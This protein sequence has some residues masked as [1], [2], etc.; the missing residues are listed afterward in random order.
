MYYHHIPLLE[1]S[2][3]RI[4]LRLRTF[5]CQ[6]NRDTS[7]F[8]P[9]HRQFRMVSRK[10][11]PQL[12]FSSSSLLAVLSTRY[13]PFSCTYLV[14][15]V[16]PFSKTNSR[17]PPRPANRCSSARKILCCN[18]SVRNQT[19]GCGEGDMLSR[20]NVDSSVVSEIVSLLSCSRIRSSPMSKS[21]TRT[22]Q[23][24]SVLS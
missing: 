7:F 2:M 24:D 17:I 22:F 18:S 21:V 16:L 19:C 8:L 14:R 9:I 12:V 23:M 11:K 1:I 5:S 6:Y 10:P 3:C 20:L 13:A 15:C 4:T